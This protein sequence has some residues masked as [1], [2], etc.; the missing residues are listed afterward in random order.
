LAA[1]L[2]GVKNFIFILGFVGAVTA[3]TDG[4]LMILIYF[5]AKKKGDRQPE[6]SMSKNKILGYILMAVF[7]LGMAY[8]FIY[9]SGK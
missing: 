2:L 9:I 6:Y 4:I 5:K 8:Q 3:G 7:L 1:F